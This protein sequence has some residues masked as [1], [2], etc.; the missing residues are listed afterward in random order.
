[1][2]ILIIYPKEKFV[3]KRCGCEEYSANPYDEL[4]WCEQCGDLYEGEIMIEETEEE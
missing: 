4:I 1:M 2:K 3:C